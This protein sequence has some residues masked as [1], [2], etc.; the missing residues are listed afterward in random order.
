MDMDSGN[1]MLGGVR[2]MQGIDG[3]IYSIYSS[4]LDEYGVVYCLFIIGLE[5]ATLP[6]LSVPCTLV[7]FTE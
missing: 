3:L 2:S 4:L 6:L 1:V 5:M 7:T